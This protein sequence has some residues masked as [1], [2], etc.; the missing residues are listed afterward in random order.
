LEEGWE[1]SRP[2]VN[3][4]THKRFWIHAFLA[5]VARVEIRKQRV[6]NGAY[7]KGVKRLNEAGCICSYLSRFIESAMYIQFK[8]PFL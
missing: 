3:P 8:Q 5:A 2:L 6:K 4:V 1:V 7:S